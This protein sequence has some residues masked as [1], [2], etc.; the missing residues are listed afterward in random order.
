M[1]QTAV[2]RVRYDINGRDNTSRALRSVQQGFT[3]LARAATVGTAA[4]ATAIALMTRRGLENVDALAKQAD[5]IGM[6]TESLRGFQL[7]AERSGITT[8]AFNKNIERMTVT[9]AQAADGIGTGTRA[10]DKLGIKVEDIANLGAD[11][12]MF[13]L[14]GAMENVSTQAEKLSI[15]Y[16]LFGQRGVRMVKILEQGEEAMRAAQQRAVELG[17][18]VSRFDASKVEQANDD[19]TEMTKIIEGLQNQLAVQF[20]PAMVAIAKKVTDLTIEFGGMGKIAGVVFD[21]IVTGV[22]MAMNGFRRF[23]ILA[24]AMETGIFQLGKLAVQ[25][26][27]G[28]QDAFARLPSI[29]RTVWARISFFASTEFDRIVIDARTMAAN[30]GAAIL[31]MAADASGPI[32]D[33][34]RGLNHISGTDIEPINVMA[35]GRSLGR[36]VDETDR[37]RK[38]LGDKLKIGADIFEFDGETPEGLQR[39]LTTMELSVAKAAKEL[40]DLMEEPMP[41]E[42]LLAKIQ[43]VATSMGKIGEETEAASKKV[44]HWLDAAAPHVTKFADHLETALVN[45]SMNGKFAIKDLA[46]FVIAEINRMFIRMLIL[47]PIFGGIGG[48]LGD[49]A[50]GNAFTNAFSNDG[51]PTALG[52][53]VMAGERRR[54]GEN[55]KS[56]VFIPDRPGRIA[57]ESETGGGTYYIDARGADRA[58]LARLEQ[59]IRETRGAIPSAAQS[60]V[61]AAFMRNPS[62]GVR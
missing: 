37:K 30:V 28:I 4:A 44:K 29:A 11:D 55:M 35:F 42:A 16:D 47:K 61:Q 58:G 33:V 59:M 24:K 1:S 41:S 36:M 45:A 10:L 31:G 7:Q 25:A 39:L 17:L 5:M 20:A 56:E 51:K 38:E 49:N 12:Q 53:R 46:K 21:T 40:H 8:E 2:R 26:A 22:G 15:A 14:A 43:E 52:G 18:T 9:L 6:S 57:T 60:A 34:I 32:N 50:V 13:M 3:A 23:R 19:W 48:L 27:I 62:F 54:V